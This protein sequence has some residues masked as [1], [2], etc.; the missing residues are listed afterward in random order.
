M[1]Q[2]VTF[3]ILA[4]MKTLENFLNLATCIICTILA[5]FQL[6]EVSRKKK[7]VKFPESFVSFKTTIRKLKT[8]KNPF[9]I[10]A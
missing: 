6:E 8:T 5:F 1:R 10:L 7:K 2:L 4:Y 3:I 9:L